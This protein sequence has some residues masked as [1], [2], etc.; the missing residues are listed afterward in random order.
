MS[1]LIPLI[2]CVCCGGEDNVH[3]VMSNLSAAYFV[4]NFLDL[5]VFLPSPLKCSLSLE[6]SDYCYRVLLLKNEPCL[7]E[8][9]LNG[10]LKKRSEIFVK[11]LL[12]RLEHKYQCGIR[13]APQRPA[14]LLSHCVL[15][16]G[17]ELDG[18]CAH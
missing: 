18:A 17:L 11:I 13:R 16:Q 9:N 7:G 14:R 12:M 8:A 3:L 5:T 15:Q 4:R 2:M 10:A 6:C 1:Y